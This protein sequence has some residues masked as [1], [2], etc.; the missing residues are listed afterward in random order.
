MADLFSSLA[1]FTIDTSSFVTLFKDEDHGYTKKVFPSF[2]NDLHQLLIKYTAI[3]HIQ[4][5]EEI[6]EYGDPDEELT[7][8]VEANRH[9]FQDYDLGCED[10][11][12]AQIGAT[13]P[14]WV[15]S[16]AGP[17]FADPWLVSQAKCRN[18]TIITEELPTV[19]SIPKEENLKIP[20]VC[21]LPY[22]QIK[23]LNVLG[24][25][26]EMNWKY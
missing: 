19:G 22:L 24:L 26:K 21:K 15:T 23:C 8:W 3:S 9:F 7:K 12:I 25:A 14:K 1:K 11:I 13:Y 18:L 5:L 6:K 10:N 20:D 2:W 17:I 4:V 16:K